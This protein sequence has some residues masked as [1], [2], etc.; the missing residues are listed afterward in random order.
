MVEWFQ[1]K[2]DVGGSGLRRTSTT[3][4]LKG[5]GPETSTVRGG[6]KYRGSMYVLREV[7]RVGPKVPGGVDLGR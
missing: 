1:G 6:L 7:W 5:F 4:L 3:D 2:R